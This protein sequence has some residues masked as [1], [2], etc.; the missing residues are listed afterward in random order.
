MPLWSAGAESCAVRR[1]R[2]AYTLALAAHVLEIW[3]G[4]PE[5]PLPRRVVFAAT[6]HDET[7]RVPDNLAGNSAGDFRRSARRAC[8]RHD[9]K[10]DRF[11]NVALS[12]SLSLGFR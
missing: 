10:F 5:V 2:A 6:D 4:L 1:V 7:L 9:F 12:L 3:E 8:P 11:G